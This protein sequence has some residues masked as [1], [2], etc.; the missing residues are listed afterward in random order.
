VVGE[1]SSLHVT[2]APAVLDDLL[3]A[4]ASNSPVELLP[5]FL[6]DDPLTL[7]LRL[8]R[9]SPPH[10]PLSADRG[11]DTARLDDCRARV[12]NAVR[13]RLPLVPSRSWHA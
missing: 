3:A 4:P 6:L 5:W 9:S 12:I 8:R 10:A 1:V 7:D 13:T 2:V 11:N